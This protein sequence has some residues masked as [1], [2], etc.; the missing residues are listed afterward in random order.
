M[1]AFL[2]Y[3]N[4]EIQKKTNKFRKPFLGAHRTVV[5]EVFFRHKKVEAV[6]AFQKDLGS[7]KVLKWKIFG[8]G[9][10]KN[11]KKRKKKKHLTGEGTM[12]QLGI[13]ALNLIS[14][15]A[16]VA[17]GVLMIESIS[18]CYFSKIPPNHR[19]SRNQLTHE[20]TPLKGNTVFPGVSGANQ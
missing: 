3:Q 9:K 8:R 17:T 14:C 12:P 1:P 13:K 2:L 10:E 15:Y 19:S 5:V 16:S 18:S 4:L 20:G 6:C 7:T 11:W